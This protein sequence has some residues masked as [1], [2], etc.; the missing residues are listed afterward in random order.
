MG[1]NILIEPVEFNQRELGVNGVTFASVFNSSPFG[2]EGYNQLTIEWEVTRVDATDLSF[3][4]A[5]LM[6]SGAYGQLRVGDLDPT[7][8]I[9]TTARRQF[10][11]P[12]MATAANQKGQLNIAIN[13]LQMRLEDIV[14][15]AA[16]TDTLVMRVRLGRT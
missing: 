6:P 12:T 16:T 1:S 11:I 10:V 4:V 14:G 7:T 13:S 5:A 9:E 3:Y 8:G 2:T 15:T